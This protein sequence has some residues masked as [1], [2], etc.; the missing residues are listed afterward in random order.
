MM[1]LSG[2]AILA[3]T[4][5][6]FAADIAAPANDWTGFS[7]GVGGGGSFNFADM[8]ASGAGGFHASGS[9]SYGFFDFD[10]G[11]VYGFGG[12]GSTEDDD[13]AVQ[14]FSAASIGQSSARTNEIVEHFSDYF[15]NLISGGGYSGGT[16]GNSDTGKAGFMGTARIGADYQIDQFVI[17]LD[18]AYNFGKTEI[19]NSAAGV[20][21]GAAWVDDG[22]GGLSDRSG[23]G[24]GTSSIDTSLEIGNSWSVGARAGFL[25]SDS[26][27]LFASAGYVSTKA[28]LEASFEGYAEAYNGDLNQVSGGGAAGWGVRAESDEWM[29]GYY[30]GGGVE[31]LLTS[32]ISLKF[33][34]RFADLGS[35]SASNSYDRFEGD[36]NGGEGHIE[37]AVDAEANPTVHTLNATVN[38]RF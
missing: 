24:T 16:D 11:D 21:G 19:E 20:G 23:Y 4:G 5:S 9:G 29:N 18:A 7:I 2:V 33:E 32:N 22:A 3:W 8:T 35:I 37:A 25:A 10:E 31:Q 38:F 30:I 26:T 14:M 17:G 27:L 28:T 13:Y 12:A 36:G 6:S 1:A 34:Y 15:N